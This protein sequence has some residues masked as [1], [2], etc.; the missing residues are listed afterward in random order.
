MDFDD[1]LDARLT[2]DVS[3]RQFTLRG[4]TFTLAASF[5]PELIAHF[6]EV[7]LL[8]PTASTPRDIAAVRAAQRAFM[9]E[10]LVESD[11][12]AWDALTAIKGD[13]ALTTED[14][15]VILAKIIERAT[16]RPPTR[17]SP[18]GETSETPEPI[19]ESRGESSLRVAGSGA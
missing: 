14:M 18:S 10:A 15:L 13:R 17:V 8:V 16:G 3:A 1:L 5:R 12:E 19:T 11:L 4:H 9:T 2:E 6:N 7:Q